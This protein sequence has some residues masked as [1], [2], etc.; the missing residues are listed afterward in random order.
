MGPSIKTTL[1][2]SFAKLKQHVEPCCMVLCR[3]EKQTCARRQKKQAL[4]RVRWGW[5]V[6][7]I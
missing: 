3:T 6:F 7:N 1:I 4:D 5:G 2:S